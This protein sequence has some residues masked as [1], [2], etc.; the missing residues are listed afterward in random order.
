V[1]VILVDWF[2]AAQEAVKERK[3]QGTNPRHKD[4]VSSCLDG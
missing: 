1:R 3:K 2:Q 4:S